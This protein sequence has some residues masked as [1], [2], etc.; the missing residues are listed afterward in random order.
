MRREDIIQNLRDAGCGDAGVKQFM[1][2][3]DEGSTTRAQRLL[4]DHRKELLNGIHE[5]ER[6]IS[7]LD[8]L[9]F[10]MNRQV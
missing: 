1:E 10:E 6:K 3:Y 4:F 7:R 9:M 8:Y 2:L 5:E